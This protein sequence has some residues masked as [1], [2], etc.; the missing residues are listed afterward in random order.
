MKAEKR[1]NDVS[2]FVEKNVV[3]EYTK[4]SVAYMKAIPGSYGSLLAG[5]HFMQKKLNLLIKFLIH[6][7]V[8]LQIGIIKMTSEN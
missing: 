6:S 5:N 7:A 8:Q 4:L 2:E 3:P 1:M